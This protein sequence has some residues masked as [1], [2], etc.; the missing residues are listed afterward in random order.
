M[1]RPLHAVA[2]LTLALL[3]AI[4][5]GPARAAPPADGI[6]RQEVHFAPGTNAARV[7]GK[8]TGHQG[9]DYILRAGAGQ[10][11][12]ISLAAKSPSVAFNLIAPGQKD[13]AFFIGAM[14]GNHYEGQL[15]A[16]GAYTVRVYLTKAAAL[17][18]ETH[19]FTLEMV[20]AAAAAPAQKAKVPPATAQK[21][22]GTLPC[23]ADRGQPMGH[24]AFV[25][26]RRPDHTADLV[27]TRLDG[28]SRLIFFDHG[29][30]VATDVSQAEGDKKLSVT[31]E[32]DLNLIRVGDERY[33]IPDA[34]I[35]GD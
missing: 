20:I 34:A 1:R 9:I 28:R 18:N 5:A 15:P 11:A 7:A 33:E 27:I 8:I 21:A 3:T 13:V 25:I 4:A 6:T 22:S 24:C 14:E 23:A 16:S 32:A 19:A 2:L 29:K 31:R 10:A 30:P 17:R 12:N 26:S 35:T